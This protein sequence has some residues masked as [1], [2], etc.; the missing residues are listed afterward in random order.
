MSA[1]VGREGE[2][3]KYAMATFNHSRPR[4]L[5]R[6][7]LELRSG[8][9]TNARQYSK[10]R[11][12]FGQRNANFQ[13]IQFMMAD[14]AIQIEAMRLLTYKAAWLVDKGEGANTITAYAKAFSAD[15]TMGNHDQRGAE[16]RRLWIHEGVSGREADARREVAPG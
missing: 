4:R 10:Q 13:A 2:G 5:A 16:S 11:N 7:R 9:S 6:S 12:A 14:M 1:L 15:A 8:R 3:F